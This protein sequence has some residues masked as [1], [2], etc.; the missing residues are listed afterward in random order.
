MFKLTIEK[1]SFIQRNISD[2]K[3][4]IIIFTDENNMQSRLQVDLQSPDNSCKIPT[5]DMQKVS[6]QIGV[7]NNN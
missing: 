1:F 4:D 5:N 2:I 3:F 7:S 6:E